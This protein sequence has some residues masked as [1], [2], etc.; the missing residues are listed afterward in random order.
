MNWQWAFNGFIIIHNRDRPNDSGEID[1]Q[2]GQAMAGE[3]RKM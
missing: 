1:P 2:I 3:K